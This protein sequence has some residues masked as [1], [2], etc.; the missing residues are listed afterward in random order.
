MGRACRVKE[1]SDW[2]RPL[3]DCGVCGNQ[4]STLLAVCGAAAG[5][6]FMIYLH[7]AYLGR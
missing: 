5:L 4:R 1:R 7:L 2:Q 6:S 3:Q